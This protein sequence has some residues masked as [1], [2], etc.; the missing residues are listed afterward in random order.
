MTRQAV[1]LAMRWASNSP[2]ATKEKQELLAERIVRWEE[3]N[4]MKD[5]TTD[6][7]EDMIIDIMKA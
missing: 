2:Q 5:I 6:T 1:L 4:D 3:D 7:M